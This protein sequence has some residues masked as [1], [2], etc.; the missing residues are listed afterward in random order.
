MK[1]MELA[2][3]VAVVTGG[4]RGIGR[5]TAAAL[6][7]AGARVAI[8]D[9]D[10]AELSRAAQE[11][12]IR[13]EYLDVTDPFAISG[14]VST[15]EESI[16]PIDIW[17]NNA[18]IMPV[19][20]ALEQN[21][22]IIRRAVDINLI[23]VINCSRII[24]R[25]MVLR[26]GG[27]IVNIS[28]VAGR[29]PAAGMAVY[30]AT[31]FGVVGFGESLDAE[32]ADRGVRVSTVFPSFTATE[33][34]DGLQPARGM[35][36]VEPQTIAMA[37]VKVLRNGDRLAVVPASL[38]PMSAAWMHFPRSLS[39]WLARRTGMDHVFLDVSEDREAYNRRIEK[40]PKI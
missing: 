27:R 7:A 20:P 29:I 30:S 40:G 33:L 25:D 32:L 21:D 5:A 18:G 37:V 15:V 6:T 26:G 2:G 9:V 14:F 34:I 8:G 3:R 24:A 23:G 36:P 12:G 19:G 38:S 17:I 31:K 11:L 22:A 1:G 35:E 10:T 4:A 39:R 13:G 28:S 16:G